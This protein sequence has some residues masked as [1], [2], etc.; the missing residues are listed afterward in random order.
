MNDYITKTT[1]RPFIVH[2]ESG[3]GKT[4][5]IAK[6]AKEVLKCIFNQTFN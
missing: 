5:V 6:F 4:S 3:C 1:S 2:G